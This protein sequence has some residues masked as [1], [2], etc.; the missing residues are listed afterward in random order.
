MIFFGYHLALHLKGG[1]GDGKV[2]H[3]L[4]FECEGL[5]EVLNREGDVVVGD[6]GIGE[7][8]AFAAIGTH[9]GIEVWHSL[10]AAEHQVFEEVSKA[11]VGGVLVA[12]PHLIEQVHRSSL[13]VPCLMCQHYQSVAERCRLV[14][15]HVVTAIGVGYRG[16]KVVFFCFLTK[17]FACRRKK[18]AYRRH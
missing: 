2:L 9:H 10:G 1:L 14:T 13:G 15:Y 11:S 16:A 7:G 4:G 17:F 3:P 12:R 18:R 8:I 6:V 5:R